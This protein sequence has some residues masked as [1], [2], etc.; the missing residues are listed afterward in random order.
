[1]ETLDQQRRQNKNR[2][3]LVFSVLCLLVVVEMLC[4]AKK[5][6]IW[7]KYVD[8]CCLLKLLCKNFFVP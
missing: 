7:W 4:L 6:E 5:E 3:C 1:M 2:V 8:A